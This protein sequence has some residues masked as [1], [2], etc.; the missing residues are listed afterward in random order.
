VEIL[1][2]QDEWLRPGMSQQ[3]P[4]ARLEDPFLRSSWIERRCPIDRKAEE[5]RNL[6]LT[7][8]QVESAEVARD[9]GAQCGRIV[10]VV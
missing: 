10:K 2:K 9:G 6:W 1:E 5:R 7:V 8:Q 4:P 3:K